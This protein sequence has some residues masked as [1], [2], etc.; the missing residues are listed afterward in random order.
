MQT[1]K[2][3]CSLDPD[4]A[5]HLTRKTPVAFLDRFLESLR[6]CGLVRK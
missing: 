6:D 4:L 5:V 3:G 1:M 2:L